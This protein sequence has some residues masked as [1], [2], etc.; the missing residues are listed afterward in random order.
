M[1]KFRAPC[2]RSLAVAARKRWLS[3]DREGA[4][5]LRLRCVVGQA[6]GVCGLPLCPALGSMGL[7]T[8]KHYCITDS[9]E[10][11]GRAAMAGPP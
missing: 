6:I 8:V 2:K 5:W 9:A 1:E 10:V 3:R 7:I 11:A 4:V